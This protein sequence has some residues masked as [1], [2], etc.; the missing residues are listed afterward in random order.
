[1]GMWVICTNYLRDRTRRG[2][3]PRANA[4]SPGRGDMMQGHQ[5]L[6]CWSV[7]WHRKEELDIPV[8]VKAIVMLEA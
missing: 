5:K 6:I 4:S 7:S 3:I 1:M 8:A 2:W